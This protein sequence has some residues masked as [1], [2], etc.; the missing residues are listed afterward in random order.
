MKIDNMR[1]EHQE[2]LIKDAEKMA[3][4]QAEQE[5]KEEAAQPPKEVGFISV[6]VG[7]GMTE[8]FKELG[9]DYLI[10]GGQTMNPSTDDILKAILATPAETVFVLPN[11]KNI[12]M[13]AE[14][15]QGIA[16]RT[17]VVLSTRTIPQGITAML[18]FDPDASEY[19]NATN[20]M[21]AADKVATGLVTFAAR[22]SDF[23]GRK[24]KKARS[25]R[26]RTVSWWPRAPTSPR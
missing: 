12:I 2:K 6:S 20:M 18:N 16:D 13:A 5:E 7:K 19:E 10:E 21:Q 4:E 24:I 3:K 11:N 25:W 23:D 1:E 8:I 15:A 14:Q 26:W 22:D 17:I 9:V